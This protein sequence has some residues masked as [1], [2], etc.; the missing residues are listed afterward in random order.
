MDLLS[1][2][3]TLLVEITGAYNLPVG[4]Q[5]GGRSWADWDDFRGLCREQCYSLLIGTNVGYNQILEIR[6]ASKLVSNFLLQST[7][8]QEKY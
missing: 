1:L 6:E 2:C 5:R 3:N 7:I 4:S 8:T